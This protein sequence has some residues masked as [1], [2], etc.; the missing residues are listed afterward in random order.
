MRRH[1]ADSQLFRKRLVKCDQLLLLL[2]ML[3][4]ALLDPSLLI[5]LISYNILW[6]HQ[7]A[8]H[9]EKKIPFEHTLKPLDL[10]E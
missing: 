8:L 3:L 7:M 10:G 1:T 2:D 6:K 4:V 9:F 5:H